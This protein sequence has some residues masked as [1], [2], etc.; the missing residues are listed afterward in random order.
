M[1][2]TYIYSLHWEWPHALSKISAQLLLTLQGMNSATGFAMTVA[3]WNVTLE[4]QL[5]LRPISTINAI[6]HSNQD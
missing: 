2:M 5:L 4:H 3:K 6:D 1:G